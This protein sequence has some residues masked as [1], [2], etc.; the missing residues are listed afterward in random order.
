M[1]TDYKI[2]KKARNKMVAKL[3]LYFLADCLFVLGSSAL[4]SLDFLKTYETMVRPQF[5]YVSLGEIIVWL[6][7]FLALSVG[8]A[9]VRWLYWLAYGLQAAALYVPLKMMGSD[10]SHVLVYLVWIFCMFIQLAVQLQMGLS[11]WRGRSAKIFY[12]HVLEVYDDEPMLE[13]QPVVRKRQPEAEEVQ[14]EPVEAAPLT[15]PQVSLRLGIC[16]YG[17]L[18]LFPMAVQMFQGFFSSYNMQNVFATR[19]MFLICIFSAFVWTIPIFFLYYSQKSTKR[20]IW[21]T[22]ALEVCFALWYGTRLLEYF[23][24]GQYPNRVFILFVAINIVR[25]A[26]IGMVIAP[27]LKGEAVPSGKEEEF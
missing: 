23:H 18:I 4:L 11:L 14:E 21:G 22:I 8:K 12:D 24:A 19:D 9:W 27:V 26:L 7:I 3:M 17:E 10:A 20:M 5:L 13:P 1:N 25:Y 15:W 2:W 6:L 16:V